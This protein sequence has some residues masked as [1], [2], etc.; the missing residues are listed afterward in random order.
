MS[1]PGGTSCCTGAVAFGNG[2]CGEGLS[3]GPCYAGDT[4]FAIGARGCAP[5][6]PRRTLHGTTIPKYLFEAD[7][8]TPYEPS[9]YCGTSM[10]Q[11]ETL[12]KR[13]SLQGFVDAVE[14]DLGDDARRAYRAF[15]A[16]SVGGQK[17][18]QAGCTYKVATNYNSDAVVDDGSCQFDFSIL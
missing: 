9:T 11:D 3:G 13:R 15:M 4:F 16:Q 7:G 12:R 6:R 1:A 17:E 5:H 10:P 18:A 8:S 2:C 14:A